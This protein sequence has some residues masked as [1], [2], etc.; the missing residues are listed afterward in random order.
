MSAWAKSGT[1]ILW[2]GRG[3]ALLGVGCPRRSFPKSL[4][5]FRCEYWP[6]QRDRQLIELPR[7]LK[8]H[9]VVAIVDRRAGVSADI[10]RFIEL[11]DDRDRTFHLWLDTTL[12]STLS[13][14][15]PPQPMPLRLL[16]ASVANPSPSYLKSN[17]T[18]CLPGE[19]AAGAVSI[20]SVRR[21]R[22]SRISLTFASSISTAV[23]RNTPNA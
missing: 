12:P 10:E 13:V 4:Y 15:V 22:A 6:F 1:F 14:P 9:F 21:A 20:A 19:S 7:K 11:Q 3:K 16:K 8:W 2:A 18:W 17:S 5:I 23:A